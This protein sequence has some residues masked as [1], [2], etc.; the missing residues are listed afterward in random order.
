MK[1][2][3]IAGTAKD[4]QMGVNILKENNYND[5]IVIENTKTPNEQTLFQ[6]S[7]SEY[8]E[9]IISSHI[10]YIIEQDCTNLFVYC[11]S[12]SASVD[13]DKLAK[14]YN[15]NIITPLHIYRNLAKAIKNVVVLSANAQ[16]LA[17]IE[18][19]MFEVNENINIVGITML[20]MVRDIEL[21]KNSN[22]ISEKFN[23]DFLAEYIN[24]L[25]VEKV[26][27]GCTHFPYIANEL[28]QKLSKSIEIVDPTCYMLELLK[29]K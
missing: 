11:N 24:S 27:L 17:G 1:I 2:A 14:K 8:K 20:D 10:K 25:A 23:F 29:R 16:G 9:K 5:L 22:I 21:G 12:L 26:I 19:V 4:T 6:I 3:V 7:T 13:F 28:S 15:I 18:K